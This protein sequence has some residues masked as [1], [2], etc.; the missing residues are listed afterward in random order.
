[1]LPTGDLRVLGSRTFPNTH[2]KKGIIEP[3]EPEKLGG[4]KRDHSGNRILHSTVIILVA[5]LHQKGDKCFVF[6]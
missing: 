5:H 1:M 4:R 2:Q 6:L 3:R